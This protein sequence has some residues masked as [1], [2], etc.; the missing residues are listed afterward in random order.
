CGAHV[1][2]PQVGQGAAD[3]ERARRRSRDA[4]AKDG[5][6]LGILERGELAQDIEAQILSL[7]PGGVS[8]PYRSS[9]GYHLFRLESKESLEGEGL[10]RAKAQIR[11]ILFREKYEA[12]LEAWLKEIKQRAVIEVRL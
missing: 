6:D 2:G 1:R 11:E 7:E 9:L 8:N 4:S 3:A 5:G 12:R 10:V